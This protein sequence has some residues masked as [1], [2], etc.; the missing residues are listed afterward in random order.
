MDIR[1]RTR[2]VNDLRSLVC[3]DF[4]KLVLAPDW[5]QKLY[6]K[7][8]NAVDTNSHR[9]KYIEAYNKMRDMGLEA[10]SVDC[11]DVSFISAIVLF[12]KD[13][14]AS[15]Q[16][17]TREA[18]K[19]VTDDRNTTFHENSHEMTEELYLRALISVVDIISFIKTV[20]SYE[21]DISEDD[22][23]VFRNKWISKAE[24][25]KSLL[26]EERIELVQIQ[27]EIDSDVAAIK[28]SEDSFRIWYNVREKYQKHYPNT[29]RHSRFVISASD[30]GICFAHC[31]AAE[32]FL[33][34]QNYDE[35]FRRI[36]LYCSANEPLSKTVAQCV[37]GRLY[38]YLVMGNEEN[39]QFKSIID[40]MRNSGIDIC[41][42]TKG[43]YII[44]K[45]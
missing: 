23:S 27:K 7:A 38:I 43:F 4:L 21:K 5:K 45:A 36:D 13:I 40:R 1:Y 6:E 11:M 15:I 22:R 19:K 44:R 32:A 30:A 25:L 20:D 17:V 34:K 37:L 33:Q 18:F 10:Y 29:D 26:D 28:A 9:E 2:D 41:Q 35:F 16:K 31:D 8:K 3:Q 14:I 24:S 42:N 39:M 12:G